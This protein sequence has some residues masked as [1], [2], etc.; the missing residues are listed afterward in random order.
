ME[1]TIGIDLGTTFCAVATVDASGRAII[2]KN[3]LGEP[4]TPSVVWFGEG[5]HPVVGAEAKQMQE[6]GE[7]P[8]S[9]EQEPDSGIDFSIFEEA[10]HDINTLPSASLTSLEHIDGVRK[11]LAAGGFFQM[12]PFILA[13]P[14]ASGLQLSDLEQRMSLAENA[15][16][17]LQR[18]RSVPGPVVSAVIAHLFDMIGLRIDDPVYRAAAAIA[19]QID[20]GHGAGTTDDLPTGE[21]NPYH[22]SNHILDLVLLCDLLGQRASLRKAPAS[23]PLARGL[24]LLAAL[25]CHWHH[26]GK[27]NKVGDQYVHFYLQDRALAYAEPYLDGMSK[28]LRQSLIILVRSTDAREPYSFCR[29][30][31]AYHV[32]LG[33]RPDVAAHCDSLSRVLG[34]PALCTLVARLNDAVFVPFAGLSA[35]YSARSMVQLG[36]EIGTPIDFGFVRKFLITP[37]LSRPVYRGE[38]PPTAL[39]VGKDRVAS[40]TSA[41]AQ[42][43]FNPTMHALML[44]DYT[45]RI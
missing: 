36:R 27:G 23:S 7:D 25:I 20:E 3:S 6:M 26:T 38:T 37:M 17:T 16:D 11:A 34:D 41:E 10:Q 13:T 19:R 9:D 2:L 5:K 39:I 8:N 24:I 15:S 30:A 21:R 45:Q 4:L 31:Y 28:E 33:P 35:A 42:A 44:A 29:A 43:L 14:Q 32:G 12:P 40:F 22:N 18:L 1:T